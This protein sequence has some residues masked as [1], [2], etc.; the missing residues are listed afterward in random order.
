[1]MSVLLKFG[2]KFL[3]FFIICLLTKHS[4]GLALTGVDFNNYLAPFES[5]CHSVLILTNTYT[6]LPLNSPVELLTPAYIKPRNLFKRCHTTNYT[7]EELIT[8]KIGFYWRLLS[9]RTCLAYFLHYNPQKNSFQYWSRLVQN[10]QNYWTVANIPPFVSERN[11]PTHKFLASFS[12]HY[13]LNFAHTAYV[14]LVGS[15]KVS[16]LFAKIFYKSLYFRFFDT[17]C[18]TG[19]V[20][21]ISEMF[22]KVYFHDLEKPGRF[23]G[24]SCVTAPADPSPFEHGPPIYHL[25]PST[26]YAVH[27]LFSQ[28]NLN[29]LDFFVNSVKR[30]YCGN[31]K[32]EI[33]SMVRRK[34]PVLLSRFGNE[35]QILDQL[36]TTETEEDEEDLRKI[37]LASILLKDKPNTTV[38]YYY[39][40]TSDPE[41]SAYNQFNGFVY[42]PKI[43][44]DFQARQPFGSNQIYYPIESTGFNFIACDEIGIP[45]SIDAYLKP[46]QTNLWISFSI[47]FVFVLPLAVYFLADKK[48][49]PIFI[50]LSYLIEQ[51][52][53]IPKKL[54]SLRTYS[55]LIGHLGLILVL[56][57]N[58]YKGIVTT[59]LLAP[60][61]T[62][63]LIKFNDVI[64]FKSSLGKSYD[65]SLNLEIGQYVFACHGL[66]DARNCIR[67]EYRTNQLN[68]ETRIRTI[69]YA[70]NHSQRQVAAQLHKRSKP[71]NQKIKLWDE[72]QWTSLSCANR[73]FG[74][75]VSKI[76]ETLLRFQSF[77]AK[78][79]TSILFYE[80]K[81]NI[82]LVD[83]GLRVENL[84]FLG[85]YG[86]LRLSGIIESGVYG[87]I[88]RE[89]KK[90]KLR[91]LAARLRVT[92]KYVVKQKLS[93]N[94]NIQVLFMGCSL[95]L[96]IA[97][98]SFAWEGRDSLVS[99]IKMSSIFKL[100]QIV[101]YR[102]N[103]APSECPI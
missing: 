80:G 28:Q 63:K 96:I 103:S 13:V 29:D 82:F 37:M 25:T 101:S 41:G 70:I 77:A 19:L 57:T 100:K 20:L 72:I 83:V 34:L 45:Y 16:P 47:F 59:D 17:E 54:G 12:A 9:K 97:L 21:H 79:G 58:A 48:L 74:T 44:I 18:N 30:E 6:L 22:S 51:T 62:H 99:F 94:I 81:E 31:F 33:Q 66:I 50:F 68:F 40:N 93:L 75:S 64:N 38:S 65:V 76:K 102:M 55:I 71:M 85:K 86:I 27:E 53:P 3:L 61:S 39:I 89:F 26:F 87:H 52:L 32:I 15:S 5:D 73:V 88:T 56:L 11:T 95:A 24:I 46:F 91:V 67:R 92:K 2:S 42:F 78:Q 98:L 23:Y 8:K 4:P 43:R 84:Q 49:R 35:H 69:V 14:N 1:M 90:Q 7:V 10:L 60:L 36:E